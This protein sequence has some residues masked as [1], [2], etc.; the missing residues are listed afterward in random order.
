MIL[1]VKNLNVS[2]KEKTKLLPILENVSFDLRENECLGILGESGSGK[3]VTWKAICGL[4]NNFD[5]KGDVIFKQKHSLLNSKN[6]FRGNEITAIVQNPM[7]SFNP[8]FSIENQ[9]IETFLAHKNISKNEAYELSVEVLEKMMINEVKKV[10]KKYPHE[11]SGG[12]LQ[13]IMIAIAIALNPSLLIADEPTTAIDSINQVKV[14]KELKRLR[15]NEQIAMIFITHD[16]HAIEAISDNVLVMHKGKVVEY[17]TCEQITK[18]PKHE[19][20]QYLVHTRDK[21]F[22][23]FKELCTKELI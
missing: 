2:V 13:R 14:L 21:L 1:E 15:E 23:K 5:I 17:G 16:L 19:R 12:M 22:N 6:H 8:L 3:S 4:L 11:L 7:T 10:L 9:M 20:T 18:D